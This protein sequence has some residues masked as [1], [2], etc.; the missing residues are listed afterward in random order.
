MDKRNINCQTN[1]LKVAVTVTSHNPITD[2]LKLRG[3]SRDAMKLISVSA[4]RNKPYHFHKCF[5]SHLAIN[6]L[7]IIQGRPAAA[8]SSEAARSLKRFEIKI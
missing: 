4:T 8:S 7:C 5:M 1:K 2:I 6:V 3:C